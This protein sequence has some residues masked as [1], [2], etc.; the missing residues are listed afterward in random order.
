[1]TRRQS[2]CGVTLLEVL[3]TLALIALLASQA[4]PAFSRHVIR[5]RRQEAQATL[6]RLMQQQERYF[7]QSNTYIEF[8]SS[9]TG[10]QARQFQWWSG[11][12]KTGS[13]YEI[14]GKP[15]EGE[16]IAQC[17]RL[18]ATPGTA[19]VDVHFRD[20]DCGQLTLTSN[21]QRDASGPAARCWP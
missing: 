3:V 2:I 15:C 16:L 10:E 9:S 21:G 20:A 14:E 12:S 4:Y 19:N 17:V 8:S 18:I 13:A 11:T 7:T 1:M 5:L 6:L